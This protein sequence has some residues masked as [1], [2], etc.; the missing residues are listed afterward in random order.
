MKI[1]LQNCILPASGK[2]KI[3]DIAID[4]GLIISIGKNLPISGFDSVFNIS[5]NYI[6]PGFT[7]LHVH[8]R[9]PGFFY[10]ETILTGS[11]AAA[12]GGFTRVCTMPNLNPAPDCIEN[13]KVQTEIIEKSDII[14]VLP[15]ATLTKGQKGAG[16]M[17]DYGALSKY[18]PAFSDDGK[19][20]QAENLMLEIM[21]E[22][23]KFDGL[24]TAH[25]EDESLLH[26][27]YIHDG[28]YAKINGHKGICSESEWGQIKRDIDLVR[29]TG[30]RYH[31]C[32]ISTKESVEL[33]RQAKAEGLPVSCETA[34]HYLMFTDMDIKD[35]GKFKMNPPIRGIADKIALIEGIKDGTIDCIATDHAPHSADEK[36]KGLKSS[37]F[38]VVGL[39]TAFSASYTA[40]VKAGHISFDKLIELMSENPNRIIR[41]ETPKIAVGEKA[42]FTVVD[43]DKKQ[44]VNPEEF[45]SMGRATPFE[46]MELWGQVVMTM[47]NGRIIWKI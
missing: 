33:I 20:I 15:I 23:K 18:A 41:K 31:V 7:D 26:G 37:A 38:G 35:D 43:L 10:K 30:C 4:S 46:G 3:V 27:G 36:S 9:E 42:T 19:G 1:L 5:K 39:E 24:I 29:K 34:P 44:I 2:K 17:V 13:I 12:R 32:H 8:F 21:T 6:I 28:E 25:C 14:E 40:L 47:R 16:E 11:L 45:R 22:I